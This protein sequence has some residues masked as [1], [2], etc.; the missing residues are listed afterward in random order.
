MGKINIMINNQRLKLSMII[1]GLLSLGASSPTNKWT[2]DL[3]RGTGLVSFRASGRPSAIRINGKGE[4]AKGTLSIQGLLLNGALTF[5]LES[6]DTGIK[7]RNEHM[8]KKYLET[9]KYPEAK[10]VFSSF[11]LPESFSADTVS[12]ALAFEGKLYLHGLEKP[13]SGTAKVQK[14]REEIS[15]TAE[16]GL[17]MSD[18]GI[19]IPSFAGITMAEDVAVEIHFTAP[20]TNI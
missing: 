19:A 4:R 14:N 18:F 17:K 15:V 13:V 9:E 11:A 6:L 10:L 7:L 5:S 20:Y 8:K 12:A 2:I 16:F 1:F 3:E